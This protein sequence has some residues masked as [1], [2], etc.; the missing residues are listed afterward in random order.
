MTGS[1]VPPPALSAYC[2]AQVRGKACSLEWLKPEKGSTSS[3]TL[4]TQG[5]VLVPA[6]GGEGGY[7]TRLCCSMTGE[8]RDQLSYAHSLEASSLTPTSSGLAVLCCQGQVQGLLT[9]SQ[10]PRSNF[11]TCYRWWR[12][13]Q[14]VSPIWQ[15]KN[16]SDLPCSH[17]LGQLTHV[18]VNWVSA[19]VLPKWGEG[20]AI[21][22]AADGKGLR[23]L[24]YLLQIDG[25]RNEGIL[26]LRTLS[27]GRWGG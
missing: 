4:M 19:T 24:S 8:Y 26:P 18:P 11:P 23:Q 16:G 25:V 17:S 15:V 12:V 10:D 6:A 20:P 5:S 21:L 7:R 22:R 1:P 14:R 2:A 27:H 9:S 13:G 3:F